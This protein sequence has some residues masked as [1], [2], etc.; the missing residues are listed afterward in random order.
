MLVLLVGAAVAFI[1]PAQPMQAD[2]GVLAFINE[3]GLDN[4]FIINDKSIHPAR[5]CKST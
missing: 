5:K 1:R 2:N 3:N 4:P